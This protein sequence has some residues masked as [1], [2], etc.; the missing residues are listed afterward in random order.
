MSKTSRRKKVERKL[1]CKLSM[2]E[3]QQRGSQP[4]AFKKPG[5]GK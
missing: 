4:R 1:A 3:S 5:S 2:W